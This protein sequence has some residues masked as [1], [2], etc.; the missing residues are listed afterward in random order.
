MR[1]YNRFLNLNSDLNCLDDNKRNVRLGNFEFFY[2]NIKVRK[3]ISFP[4]LAML[5]S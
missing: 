4:E 5:F 2:V 3:V 1:L